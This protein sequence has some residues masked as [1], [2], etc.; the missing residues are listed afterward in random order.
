MVLE[1]FLKLG[2]IKYIFKMNI[3]IGCIYN[4]IYISLGTHKKS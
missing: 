1:L 3:I 4:C 2:E